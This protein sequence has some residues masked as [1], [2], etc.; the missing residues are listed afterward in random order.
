MT[1]ELRVYGRD[2]CGFCV[3]ATALLKR[4]NVSYQYMDVSVPDNLKRLKELDPTVKTIPQIFTLNADG[5][6]EHHIGGFDDLQFVLH[7]IIEKE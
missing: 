4:Y 3:K 1:T 2:D 5:S 7:R 6:E